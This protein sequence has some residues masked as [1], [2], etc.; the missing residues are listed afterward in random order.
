M[1]V[2]RETVLRNF[3]FFRPPPPYNTWTI[4]HSDTNMLSA[5]NP[6]AN[7]NNPNLSHKD[8]QI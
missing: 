3:F 2:Y 8:H 6:Q 1:T 5:I 7:I 4:V